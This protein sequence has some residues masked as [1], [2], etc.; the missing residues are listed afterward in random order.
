MIFQI[1]QYL[2][3]RSY[4][5]FKKQFV[6]VGFLVVVSVVGF[7]GNVLVVMV[8]THRYQPS[9]T[10]VFILAMAACDLY[11]NVVTI[12]LAIISLRYA[13]A[14]ESI[15]LCRATLGSNLSVLFSST[16]LVPVAIDRCRNVWS[17]TSG[18]LS[19]QKSII[20]VLVTILLTCAVFLPFT[21]LYG[22][23]LKDT[24]VPG[25]R[26]R[27]C[28]VDER[29]R[30]S[31]FRTAFRIVL[32]VSVFF[33]VL[34]LVTAYTL[35][36]IKLEKQAKALRYRAPLFTI[37]S[38]TQSK[39][40]TSISSE[41]QKAK[42][43]SALNSSEVPISSNK[44][45][46]LDTRSEGFATAKQAEA[47]DDM[48]D[49]AS[50]QHD[51]PLNGRPRWDPLKEGE[52]KEE[53]MVLPLEITHTF[54]TTVDPLCMNQSMPQDDDFRTDQTCEGEGLV[55][56]LHCSQTLSTTVDPGNQDQT[57]PQESKSVCDPQREKPRTAQ[58][59]I[60]KQALGA[61]DDGQSQHEPVQSAFKE[62]VAPTPSTHNRITLAFNQDQH[63]PA[64][65][66][67]SDTVDFPNE[68]MNS[69]E[70]SAGDAADPQTAP[71]SPTSAV[72][73]GASREHNELAC[74]QGE[75]ICRRTKEST[76]QTQPEFLMQPAP[77]VYDVN[78]VGRYAV[79]LSSRKVKSR[80]T[81][82][83]C[84]LTVLYILNWVPHLVRGSVKADLSSI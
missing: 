37:D 20:V 30:Y 71:D 67:N 15:A 76:T 84:L 21:Y 18:Q 31:M 9:S 43:A 48:V 83:M 1:D 58:G 49:M 60:A 10:S 5:A 2:A 55:L 4:A 66:N 79:G 40:Y 74:P 41:R 28:W 69:V 29:Y 82:M 46:G 51:S 8:Y 36:G 54:I 24:P 42:T 6:L 77:T 39:K 57:G 61:T 35:I 19:H 78:K 17:P 72:H 34:A 14:N 27:L 50:H 52:P 81:K 73:T 7:I 32:S 26:A 75:P 13:Y 70:T 3:E 16:L 25:V 23:Y 62:S 22:I 45:E 33:T 11:T 64:E 53:D 68:I 12:P 38:S 44:T 80:T 56:Q 63:S 47:L 65:A 59:E